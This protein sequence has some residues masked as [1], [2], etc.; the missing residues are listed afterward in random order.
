M[1]KGNDPEAIFVKCAML[2]RVFRVS[3]Q[4]ISEYVKAGMPRSIKGNY[5]LEACVHWWTDRKE[6]DLRERIDGLK[7]EEQETRLKRAQ[8][9]YKEMELA[10]ERGELVSISEISEQYGLFV[11]AC[12]ARILGIGTRIAPRLLACGSSAEMKKLID[13]ENW[14][15]LDELSRTPDLRTLAEKN[16][17]VSSGGFGRAPVVR[18]S[19]RRRTGH[20]KAA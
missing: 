8:A 11:A 4:Q 12:R 16:D 6:A 19:A 20:G 10:R 9:D 18:R 5:N 15:A 2:E 14:N 17:G 3:Q 13:E 1:K 7:R